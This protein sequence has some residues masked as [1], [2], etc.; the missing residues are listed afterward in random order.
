MEIFLN[1]LKMILFGVVEGITEWLP[2]SSTG[3]M[4]ILEQYLNIE[5]SIGKGF[6]DLFLVVIQLGAILAVIISF[7][8]KIWPFGFNRTQEEKKD[9]WHIW[10]NILIACL[11]VGI[12]GLFA[13]DWLDAHLYNFLT[14]SI[15]L[16]V[17]GIAFVVVES[18]FQKKN[19]QSRINDVKEMTW[20]TALIIGLAQMLALIPGTSRSGVTILAALLLGCS[21]STS[22]EFSFLVSIPVMVAASLYKIVKFFLAGNSLA[23]IEI[24]YLLTGCVV[25]FLVSLLV[26]KEFM[27]FIKSK[28]FMGFGIYRIV[29][30]CLL[31][32]VFFAAIKPLNSSSSSALMNFISSFQ[33]IS[34]IK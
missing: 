18:L 19:W 1:F 14:V 21:R 6:Y 27:T 34:Y 15:A 4:I 26:L 22:A 33:L 32:V 24:L 17:Y 3:H 31:L 11:P 20:N 28:T 16:I 25:A 13:N 7:F 2:V 12:V 8:K 23:N 29:F 9:I 5:G 30:G 10:L